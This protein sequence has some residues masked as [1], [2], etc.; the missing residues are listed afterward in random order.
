MHTASRK[1][2]CHSLEI[3]DNKLNVSDVDE[4]SSSLQQYLGTEAHG[5]EVEVRSI[6]STHL[7]QLG[8]S[9][10]PTI[11]ALYDAILENWIAP[12]PPHV[13]LSLIHI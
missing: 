7:L 10:Q 6:A 9:P 12:L 5:D 8:D 2:T 11:S 1:L 3:A 13:P 4:A